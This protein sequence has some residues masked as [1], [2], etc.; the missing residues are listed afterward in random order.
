MRDEHYGLAAFLHAPERS[1]DQLAGGG[2]EVSR[3][4]VSEDERGVVHQRAGDG[5]ALHLAAGKLVRAVGVE[6]FGKAYLCKS[7]PRPQLAIGGGAPA[8][9][10]GEHHVSKHRGT[11]EQVE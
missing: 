6:A 8:V 11:W 7:L 2:V 1:H 5:H 10:Q 3:G 9:D 4:F